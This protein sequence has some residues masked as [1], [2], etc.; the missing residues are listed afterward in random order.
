MVF[1]YI[2]Q[3]L[4]YCFFYICICIDVYTS[5]FNWINYTKKK[6][7]KNV[8]NLIGKIGVEIL[9]YLLYVGLSLIP[10]VK[11]YLS[12]IEKKIRIILVV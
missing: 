2:I 12:C 6:S 3:F 10:F 9:I 4:V 8:F 1:I 7:F 11:L 5:I